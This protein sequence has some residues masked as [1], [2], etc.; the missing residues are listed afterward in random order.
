MADGYVG[1]WRRDREDWTAM[2]QWMQPEENILAMR[3]TYQ[4]VSFDPRDLMQTAVIENQ[5]QQGACQGHDL[6]SCLEWIHALQ[7]GSM[8]V[9]LSRA[10]AYYET[11]RIDGIRGDNGSTISGGVKLAM[12]QGVPEESKWPY[13]SR[14]NNRRP[15]FF[16]DVLENAARYKI[17]E[18]YKLT[19]YQSVRTWLGSGQG[20]IS[21]GIRWGSGMSTPVLESFSAGGG[22]HAIALLC[23]SEREGSNGEPYVWMMNSWGARWG[24]KGWS[25]WSPDAIRQM[26]NHQFTVAIGM[27]DMPAVKP[28]TFDVDDWKTALEA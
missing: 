2:Q 27:S 24:N 21:I 17:A 25:E 26:M 8:S 22:G 10:Y 1:G 5:G 14:Y 4:E 3:G 15:G 7:T 6:S 28:R 18:S 12:S 16:D 11:Q 19:S 13:P 9:Q 20:A 23:L